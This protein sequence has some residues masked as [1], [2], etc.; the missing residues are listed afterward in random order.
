MT[1]I[2]P[3]DTKHIA[4]Y[5]NQ[6][7]YPKHKDADELGYI[8]FETAEDMKQFAKERIAGASK[9]ILKP[10]DRVFHFEKARLKKEREDEV[11]KQVSVESP[12]GRAITIACFLLVLLVITVGA[13]LIVAL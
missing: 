13:G 3:N 10:A 1:I 7:Y 9:T 8:H 2:K 5:D 6:Y 12:V 11:Y 4:Y